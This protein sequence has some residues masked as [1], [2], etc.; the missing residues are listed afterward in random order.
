MNTAIRKATPDDAG[1]L[2]ALLKRIGWFD[3]FNN[4]DVEELAGQVGDRLRQCLADGSHL[5]LVA[6]TS[7]GEIIGYGSVH[8]LPYLF[9]SGPEGNVSELFVSPAARGQGIGRELLKV[10][11][12]EA[13]ER[14]CQRMSL[15]NL[16][17]RESYMR[18]FYLKAGWR[19]RSEAANFIYTLT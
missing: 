17:H 19:E 2:A 13:R 9:M 10:I 7:G 5:V 11:E 6:E 15:I 18:Q 16:R 12:R 3:R 8:W 14:G 1:R 4:L